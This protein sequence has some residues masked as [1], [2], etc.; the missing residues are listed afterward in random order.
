MKVIHLKLLTTEKVMNNPLVLTKD[1]LEEAEKAVLSNG[2]VYLDITNV[3]KVG[4]DLP[5]Y[6]HDIADARYVVHI[7]LNTT[8]SQM[9]GI[10][11]EE[12]AFVLRRMAKKGVVTDS[13]TFLER[14]QEFL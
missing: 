3:F 12:A 5:K 2:K 8:V 7:V 10:G 13:N 9:A 1:N 11:E 4:G 6:I 14:L